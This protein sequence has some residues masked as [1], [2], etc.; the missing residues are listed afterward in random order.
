MGLLKSPFAFIQKGWPNQTFT[1][2]D[3]Y[4]FIVALEISQFDNQ[5][6]Q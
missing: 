5:M 2:D 3:V 4:I 6:D 1:I